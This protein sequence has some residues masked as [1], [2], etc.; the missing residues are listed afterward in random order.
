MDRRRA[1]APRRAC[2]FRTRSQHGITMKRSQL[3]ASVM[4]M[5]LLLLQQPRLSH[6]QTRT[7][8]HPVYQ[9]STCP[10]RLWQPDEV[11]RLHEI[12]LVMDPADF[13]WQ[14]DNQDTQY[15]DARDMN[16]TTIVMDGES[17]A[18]GHFKVHGGKYQRGGE[19]PH[20]STS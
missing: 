3:A 16:I 9:R 5:L 7:A 17:F 18:G 20:E 19:S 6:A 10:G 8:D 12:N 15:E 2:H 13:R 1:P 14:V 11:P 4:R